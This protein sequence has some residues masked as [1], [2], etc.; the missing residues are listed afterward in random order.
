MENCKEKFLIL[1]LTKIRKL[2]F[3]VS[4]R[5]CFP[6]LL[7][8]I[9]LDQRHHYCEIQHL[10]LL[11]HPQG[12]SCHHRN[13]LDLLETNPIPSMLPVI[14]YLPTFKCLQMQC[15]VVQFNYFYFYLFLHLLDIFQ[16]K[17]HP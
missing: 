12:Q 8:N 3:I 4:S 13:K 6:I 10:L 2:N 7:L 15:T 9:L 16:E 1:F 11:P 17:C 14:L 5:P